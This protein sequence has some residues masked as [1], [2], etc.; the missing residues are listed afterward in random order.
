MKVVLVTGVAGFIGSA[1]VSCL[2]SKG[3]S[4]VR[5][6]FSDDIA[7][8]D[9]V[10]KYKSLNISHVFHLAARTYIPESWKNPSEFYRVSLMGTNN[11]LELC[12]HKNI[13][14]TYISAYLYGIPKT[15]PIS[16]EHTV[17][18]NN[19]YAHSKYLTEELC[20]FYA[21]FYGI[22]VAI[23]RPFNVY[24]IGQRDIFL[25]PSVIKQ[26]LYDE[27]IK[28]ENIAPKRDYVYLVDVVDALMKTMENCR[29]CETYNIGSG[30]S[31]SVGEIVSIIQKIAGTNK[32][33]HSLEKPRKCEI[34]DVIADTRKA[35]NI[36]GWKPRYSFE[37]GIREILSRGVR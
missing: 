8:C 14:L 6:P 9:L 20:R 4:V 35:Q 26:V 22:D 3:I 23:V 32:E 18:P 16:E 15:L 29:G 36:L 19:P 25:I 7:Q 17:E 37:Q 30:Y 12:R 27:F 2:E 11:I 28:V 34:L 33:V 10:Q 13:S 21:N 1:L 5:F 31:L 24:G